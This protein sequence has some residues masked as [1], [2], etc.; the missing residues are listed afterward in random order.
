MHCVYTTF[1]L[2]NCQKTRAY[3]RYRVKQFL[4]ERADLVVDICIVNL[5]SYKD[6]IIGISLYS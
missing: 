2:Y 6:K 1:V 3:N 4:N 5:L